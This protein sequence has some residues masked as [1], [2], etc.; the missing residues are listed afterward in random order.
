M[1]DDDE[2][3]SRANLNYIMHHTEFPLD[4]TGLVSHEYLDLAPR[5]AAAETTRYHHDE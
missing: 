3:G 1:D 5:P 4:T 2:S